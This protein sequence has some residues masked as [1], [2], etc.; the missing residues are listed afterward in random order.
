[1]GLEME[2]QAGSPGPVDRSCPVNVS[3]EPG[4]PGKE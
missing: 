3:Q 1:M 4:I 2:A